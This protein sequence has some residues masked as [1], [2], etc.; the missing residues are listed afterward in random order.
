VNRWSCSKNLL[1]F[2]SITI[3]S[4]LFNRS[5]IARTACSILI[6]NY[7]FSGSDS[8]LYRI[9]TVFFFETSIPLSCTFEI[10]LVTLQ[11]LPRLRY[12]IRKSRNDLLHG[13]TSYNIRLFWKTDRRLQRK[14][15]KKTI[16]KTTSRKSYRLKHE[17]SIERHDKQDRTLKEDQEDQ[18]R[19]RGRNST[20]HASNV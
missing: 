20:T 6:S 16:M 10:D 19:F 12:P 2:E 8:N 1:P 13:I 14:K 5:R 11:L 7:L 17:E 3:C 15:R 4:L 18:I 9:M